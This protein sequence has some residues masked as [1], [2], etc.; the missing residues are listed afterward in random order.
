MNS[1]WSRLHAALSKYHQRAGFDSRIN[2]VELTSDGL[3]RKMAGPAFFRKEFRYD[4]NELLLREI[5]FLEKL[6]GVFSP[7]LINSG[8]GWLEMEY[9]GEEITCANLPCDWRQQVDTIAD[10]LNEARIIHR[11]IKTG[12]VLVKDG[13]L[14]LI[15]FGWA[16]WSDEI[17]YI[18]PREMCAEIPHEHIYDN[19]AA[20]YWLISK[21]AD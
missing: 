5:A 15:D 20:L 9:C 10:G 1:L 19:Y 16:I 12:N 14:Y 6:G 4:P 18:C 2:K 7:K 11:D 8:D 21:Y 17:P 3:V 13:R